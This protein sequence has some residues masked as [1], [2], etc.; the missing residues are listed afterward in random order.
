MEER[1]TQM[2]YI[3]NTSK[4]LYK[5]S[6]VKYK[7]ILTNYKLLAKE[8][9]LDSALELSNLFSYMLWNGYYSVTKNHYYNRKNKLFLPGMYSFDV[10]KGGGVCLAYSELLNNYL[11]TC[12][13][14]SALL[15]CV[16]SNKVIEPGYRPN[17]ER[18]VK[19]SFIDLIMKNM[20][21][22]KEPKGAN[23]AVN[24]IKE[25]NKMF[26]Y[27]CTNLYVFNVINKNVAV[28]VNGTGKI[29]LEPTTTFLIPNSDTC[30]LFNELSLALVPPAFTKEDVIST[31]DQTMEIVNS[32]I[33]LLDDAYD[34][35]HP[36]LEFIDKQTNKF[37][38]ASK[39]LKKMNDN[40]Y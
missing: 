6:L 16:V 4:L 39:I 29:N 34:N 9:K 18:N 37:G 26:I 2:E 32:N 36:S 11:I 21:L 19:E 24:L 35:I 40:A 12:G 15:R 1:M 13:K 17:V 25:D 10:I 31:F 22:K 38:G 3:I 28:L 20:P 14:K 5:E 7:E 33:S 27:D 23:H 8:L 30:S